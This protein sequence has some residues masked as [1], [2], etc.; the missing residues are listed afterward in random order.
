MNK[1][2]VILLVIFIFFATYLVWS[3]NIML[4]NLLAS[5]IPSQTTLGTGVPRFSNEVLVVLENHSYEDVIGNAAMPYVNTL[6]RQY[7]LAQNY[8][9]NTHPSIGDYFMLATGQIITNNDNFNSLISQDNIVSV[10]SDTGKTW[11]VY[12]EDIPRTGY[13]GGNVRNYLKRHVPIV[14]LDTVAN[15]PALRSNIVPFTQFGQDLA[16]G[17]LPDFAWIVPNACNDAHDC[18]LSTADT[19]LK[20]NIDPL[21][22]NEEF[23]NNGLLAVVFDEGNAKDNAHGGGHVPAILTGAHVRPGY[24]STVFYQHQNLLRTLL[25]GLGATRFPGSAASASAMVDFFMR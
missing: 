16:S 13:I 21:L 9:A 5:P 12:A 17:S 14:Y 24:V 22:N 23:R 10:I 4:S 3:G 8:Y 20:N 1:L 15:D 7:G 11:K 25:E 6:A 2:F 18:P 19:W